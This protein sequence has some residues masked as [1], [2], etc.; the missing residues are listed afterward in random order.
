MPNVGKIPKLIDLSVAT[1]GVRKALGAC[2]EQTATGRIE[3]QCG[4][5]EDFAVHAS[6]AHSAMMESL[7]QDPLKLLRGN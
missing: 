7:N 4:A 1:A 3:G 5:L 6:S 2:N